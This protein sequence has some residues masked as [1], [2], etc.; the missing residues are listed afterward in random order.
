MQLVISCA[1]TCTMSLI[2][3]R[4]DAVEACLRERA[5]S[6]SA[7]L[8]IISAWTPAESMLGW[9]CVG[10]TFFRMHGNHIPGVPKRVQ[11]TASHLHMQAQSYLRTLFPYCQDIGNLLASR[12]DPYKCTVSMPHHQGIPASE[13]RMPSLARII[14]ALTL[15]GHVVRN[16]NAEGLWVANQARYECDNEN[17][18]STARVVGKLSSAIDGLVTSSVSF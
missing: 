2:K 10:Q 6:M 12:S 5:R 8:F 14:H 9:L 4:H 15:F 18:G 3:C 17:D 11:K 13:L 7:C 1:I 16:A